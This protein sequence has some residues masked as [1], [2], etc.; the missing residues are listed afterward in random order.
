MPA[1]STVATTRGRGDRFVRSAWPSRLEHGTQ[2]EPSR[3]NLGEEYSVY[4]TD[5]RVNAG[6]ER[7]KA[8]GQPDKVDVGILYERGGMEVASVTLT[9]KTKTVRASLY[10]TPDGKI[11]QLLIYGQ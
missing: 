3:T 9:Y 5:E 7:L 8:L 2:R 6:G 11:Q 1:P 10:R 4:L